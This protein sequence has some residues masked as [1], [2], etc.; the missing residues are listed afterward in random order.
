MNLNFSVFALDL[1][2]CRV[3]YCC[4]QQLIKL[5]LENAASLAASLGPNLIQ[6]V[7][8]VWLWKVLSNPHGAILTLVKLDFWDSLELQLQS[9]KTANLQLRLGRP[10]GERGVGRSYFGP[11]PAR[12]WQISEGNIETQRCIFG[13]HHSTEIL[14]YF[15]TIT[16]TVTIQKS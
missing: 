3:G 4:P 8:V 11:W 14:T 15:C 1:C 2:K 9:C 10:S 16:V 13:Q 6:F 12:R 5:R 7:M